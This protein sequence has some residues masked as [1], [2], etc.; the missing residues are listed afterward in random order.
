MTRTIERRAVEVASQWDASDLALPAAVELAFTRRGSRDAVFVLTSLNGRWQAA[1]DY[2][3]THESSDRVVL[4][5]LAVFYGGSLWVCGDESTATE[6]LSRLPANH[7][8]GAMFLRLMGR[9]IP[10]Q[11]WVDR[12]AAVP[13]EQCLNFKG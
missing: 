12:M 4:Q 11:E 3:A 7:K 13:L 5:H 10:A 9:G 8:M 2:L 6:V 1:V